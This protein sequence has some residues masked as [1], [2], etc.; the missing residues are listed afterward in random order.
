MAPLAAVCLIATAGCAS[1]PRADTGTATPAPSA[2]ANSTENSADNG[3]LEVDNQDDSRFTV[4]VMQGTSRITVG[5]IWGNA[6]LTMRVPAGY[7]AKDGPTRFLAVPDD[8]SSAGLQRLVRL[9]AGGTATLTIPSG[10]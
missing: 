4:Y 9:S 7:L 1:S 3:M 8:G 10:Y 6:K 5:S 2:S